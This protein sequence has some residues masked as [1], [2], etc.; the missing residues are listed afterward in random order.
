[1]L[2]GFWRFLADGVTINYR[3]Y[4]INRQWPPVGLGYVRCQSGS[5]QIRASGVVLIVST[6][7]SS[8]PRI[9]TMNVF[10]RNVAWVRPS[11][12]RTVSVSR[13]AARVQ[14]AS[15]WPVLP[16]SRATAQRS[17][18]SKALKAESA[19]AAVKAWSEQHEVCFVSTC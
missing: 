15:R 12:V 17:F 19:I 16:C 1:M 13:S 6:A 9:P 2:A 10:C 18:T 8:L 14:C 7:T 11:A 4:V 3:P 5:T